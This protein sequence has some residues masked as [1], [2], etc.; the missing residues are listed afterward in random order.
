MVSMETKFVPEDSILDKLSE[1]VTWKD[2]E[3]G[4]GFLP[5]GDVPLPLVF[6]GQKAWF[7]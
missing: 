6:E 3:K 4:K 1:N 7:E 5:R 2:T